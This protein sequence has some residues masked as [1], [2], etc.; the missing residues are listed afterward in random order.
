[1]GFSHS[2]MRLCTV[3]YVQSIPNA[4]AVCSALMQVLYSPAACKHCIHWGQVLYSQ[5]ASIVFPWGQVLYSLGASTLF[6]ERQVMYSQ[7]ACI[8]F[9][10]GKYC[11]PLGQVL[12]SLG[13]GTVFPGGKYCIPLGQVLYL[14]G[15]VLY[16]PEA[17]SVFLYIVIV[18]FLS[19]SLAAFLCFSFDSRCSLAH[20]L[21]GD[22]NTRVSPAH[23]LYVFFMYVLYSHTVQK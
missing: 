11:I 13:A 18:L 17:S 19:S 2:C 10:G 3:A 5:A 8:V 15:K 12:Y 7:G 21:F 20:V 6:P 22:T 4:E 16:S 14:R 9:P 23:V 1:M